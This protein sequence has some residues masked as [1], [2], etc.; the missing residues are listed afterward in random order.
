MN[1]RFSEI[2]GHDG[3]ID[4]VDLQLLRGGCTFD[5]SVEL[6]D[7]NLLALNPFF[8]AYG[9]FD[10]ADGTLKL[11]TENAAK[12]GHCVGYVKPLFHNLA[13]FDLEKDH[14]EI[15]KLLWD[16]VLG[17]TAFALKNQP[18]GR[19][20][21]RI[22]V[23]G[24]FEKGHVDVWRSVGC[25]LRNAFVR[26]LLPKLDSSAETTPMSKDAAGHHRR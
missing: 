7:V 10:V 1:E 12:D 23:E 5:L 16:G 20:G 15:R 13:V 18:T 2:P 9:K 6:T 11:F 25:L 17:T 8:R 24:T 26:A 21:A 14:H 3:R 4:D 22:P 19:L